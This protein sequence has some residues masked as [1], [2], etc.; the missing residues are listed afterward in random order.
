MPILEDLLFTLSFWNCEKDDICEEGTSTTPKLIIEFYDNTSPTNLKSVTNL[1]VTADG[2][3][4]S[5]NFDA[6]N[7]IELPLKTDADI[8]NYNLVFD[9]ENA[10]VALQNEDKIT[11]NYGRRDVYIS[12]AC[13]FKTVYD[14]KQNPNGMVLTA[15]QI[16]QREPR[17]HRQLFHPHF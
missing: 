15:D 9:S 6:V 3:D 1:K 2:V 8:V 7:K 12:R 11:I 4:T 14:L 16:D 17:P 10:N 13:G 5:L